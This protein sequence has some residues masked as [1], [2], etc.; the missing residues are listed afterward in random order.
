[1]IEMKSI[2]QQNFIEESTKIHDGIVSRLNHVYEYLESQ[3]HDDIGCLLE[4]FFSARPIEEDLVD[5]LSSRVKDVL[6]YFDEDNLITRV[7]EAL[8]MGYVHHIEHVTTAQM[9]KE[10]GISKQGLHPYFYDINDLN[11]VKM[12]KEAN[13]PMIPVQKY[14]RIVVMAERSDFERFKLWFLNRHNRYK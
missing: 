10:L 8:R 9:C 6:V 1:M 5:Q 2:T 13:N 12:A 3:F 7:L 14:V 4:M 11:E